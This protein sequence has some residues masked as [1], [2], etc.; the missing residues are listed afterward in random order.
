MI[1]DMYRFP[2]IPFS[3]VMHKEYLF[4]CVDSDK[5][6]KGRTSTYI[7]HLSVKS[8]KQVERKEAGSVTFIQLSLEKFSKKLF[9]VQY[10]FH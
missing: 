6:P 9:Y 4:I 7:L 2:N 8:K 1:W 10:S 5:I 3:L